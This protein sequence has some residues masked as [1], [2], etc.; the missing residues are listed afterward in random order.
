MIVLLWSWVQGAPRP[1]EGTDKQASIDGPRGSM[2]SWGEAQGSQDPEEGGLNP[3]P[4][5]EKA[6]L[7][8]GS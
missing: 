8:M 5:G 4:E 2:L 3:L 6:G 1:A 7:R